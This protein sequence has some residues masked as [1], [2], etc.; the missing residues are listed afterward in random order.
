M[1][2]EKSPGLSPG[3]LFHT[4][5]MCEAISSMPP[6]LNER[7]ARMSLIVTL[8]PSSE[9]LFSVSRS[10][11]RPEIGVTVFHAAQK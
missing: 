11:R 8:F 3:A 9:A 6:N 1:R 2:Q 7:P 4:N 5:A 10:L